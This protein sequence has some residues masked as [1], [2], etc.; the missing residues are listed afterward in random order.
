[1]FF[2]GKCRNLFNVTKEIK[3]KQMGGKVND[4][5]TN[6]FQKI[7]SGQKLVEKDLRRLTR[8]DLTEDERFEDTTLKEKKKIISSIKSI[9]KNFFDPD[10]ADTDVKIGADTGYFICKYCKN[11]QK[12]KPGTLIYSKNYI[13]SSQTE[14]E[15]YTYLMYDQ[16]L[17]RTKNYICKNSQ[18][19][20]HKNIQNKEAA[21]TKN[22][23]DQVV[24]ICTVCNTNWINSQS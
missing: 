7:G 9:N 2:C 13:E 23:E 15:D 10:A 4:A 5:L 22:A 8:K 14:T 21:L 19:D 16:T 24:Y 1:M 20:T 17:V 18:C 12:I 3:H 11:Y 6:L